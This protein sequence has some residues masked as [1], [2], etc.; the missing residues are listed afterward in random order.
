MP[1]VIF[2]DGHTWGRDE[3]KQVWIAEG[4]DPALWPGQG[5]W[6]ILKITGVSAA[7]LRSIC[8]EQTES[9]AGID[10]GDIF[11]R[12]RCHIILDALTAKTR[13][14]LTT[15]GEATVTRA[16]VRPFLVRIRDGAECVPGNW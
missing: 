11:R 10:T 13:N 7:S 16:Q 1:V 6:V 15:Q 3:S 5:M 2:D 8:D 4:R 12:R 14:D 9:D